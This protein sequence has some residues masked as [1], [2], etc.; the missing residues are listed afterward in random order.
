MDWSRVLDDTSAAAITVNGVSDTG[1]MHE[2]CELLG[3]ITPWEH[4]IGVYRNG[5]RVWSGPVTLVR[6]LQPP[7]NLLARVLTGLAPLEREGHDALQ[8]GLD[9]QRGG[10]QLLGQA[11]VGHQK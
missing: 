5:L 1:P 6:L 10:A 2:C 9:R 11:A 7:A 3:S 4:E 8:A